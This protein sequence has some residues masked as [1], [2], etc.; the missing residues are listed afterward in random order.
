MIT[1][2]AAGARLVV[3]AGASMAEERDTTLAW[4]CAANLR[5]YDEDPGP[6]QMNV[7]SVRE[8]RIVDRRE[9]LVGLYARQILLKLEA[10][11]P[12]ILAL[13]AECGQQAAASRDL[14]EAWRVARA[15]HRPPLRQPWRQALRA[16]AWSERSDIA[17]TWAV[18]AELAHRAAQMVTEA[19]AHLDGK[20]RAKL[21]AA[22]EHSF[23]YD[24]LGSMLPS[25][26]EARDAAQLAETLR[27]IDESDEPPERA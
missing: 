13:R 26:M 20:A 24:V 1:S 8:P 5:L 17:T 14:R 19:G 9:A 2:G 6:R 11:Y 12:R 23:T 21:L 18:G 10:D 4:S 27:Q 16:L 22:T 3:G 7:G 15:R 25:D